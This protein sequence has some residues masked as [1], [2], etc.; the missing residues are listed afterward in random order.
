LKAKNVPAEPAAVDTATA[1][2]GKKR[3]AVVSG[4]FKDF[5]AW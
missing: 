1:V 2:V 4:E 3:K 5:S